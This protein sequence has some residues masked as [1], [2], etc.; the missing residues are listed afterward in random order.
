M[1][2]NGT[3]TFMS[4]SSRKLQVKSNGQSVITVPSHLVKSKGWSDGEELEWKIN[5][6]GNL[7]L[8][9]VYLLPLPT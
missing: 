7:E 9:V 8:I 5:D 4:S 1:Y 2:F 3:S 6:N